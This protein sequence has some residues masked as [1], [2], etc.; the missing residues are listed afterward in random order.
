MN[1]RWQRRFIELAQHVAGW[2]KDPSTQVGAVIVR[3]DKT[4]ASLGFNGFPR[5]V[6]DSSERLVDRPTK[7]EIIV[8]AEMNAILSARES[9]AG[10]TI[11][12]WPFHPCS[13]C[14][15]GIIQA[16]ISDVYF[17]DNTVERWSESTTLAKI[18][19]TEANVN[20]HMIAPVLV[21]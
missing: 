4:I 2:S 13:R 3:P 7:Y 9:L 6:M 1:A 14:A 11:F 19:F 15:G 5:G 12:I 8:H 18:M 10:Y 17:V 16:G 21:C 20:I